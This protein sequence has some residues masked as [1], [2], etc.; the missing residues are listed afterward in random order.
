MRSIANHSGKNQD[1]PSVKSLLCLKTTTWPQ[2]SELEPWQAFASKVLREPRL[3][4]DIIEEEK[5][6]KKSHSC[7]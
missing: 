7:L 3:E 1:I 6:N 2:S 5:K 4:V